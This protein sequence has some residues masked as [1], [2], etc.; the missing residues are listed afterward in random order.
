MAGT[1]SWAEHAQV[2]RTQAS[3]NAEPVVQQGVAWGQ[4]AAQGHRGKAGPW[5]QAGNNLVRLVLEREAGC[6][7]MRL[8]GE[9]WLQEAWGQGQHW[10]GM[11]HMGQ[12][13]GRPDWTHD[14]F[15]GVSARF[16]TCVA[17]YV[18]Y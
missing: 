6:L 11:G 15:M 4:G 14:Q 17:L 7:W 2:H 5:G 13:E 1:A 10:T 8:E 16:L 3:K 9:C 12:G 18:L